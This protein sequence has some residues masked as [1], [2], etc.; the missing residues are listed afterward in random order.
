MPE[1]K[2]SGKK[3]L[4]TGKPR[5][6]EMIR[7]DEEA[8]NRILVSSEAQNYPLTINSYVLRKSE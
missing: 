5:Q 3:G 4:K 6:A 1:V 2:L 7:H 8:Q